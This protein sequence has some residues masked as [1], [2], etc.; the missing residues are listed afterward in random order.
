MWNSRTW[1]CMKTLKAHEGGVIAIS[2]GKSVPSF[3]KDRTVIT[4]YLIKGRRAYVTNIE[5]KW[6]LDGTVWIVSLKNVVNIYEV[7]SAGTKHTMDFKK[8][9]RVNIVLILNVS[10]LFIHTFRNHSWFYQSIL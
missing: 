5:A 6:S 7:K 2:I 4:Y 3:R 8:R 10:V 9:K 1:N